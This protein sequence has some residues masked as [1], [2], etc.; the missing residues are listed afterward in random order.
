MTQS[1]KLFTIGQFADVFRK[2]DPRGFALSEVRVLEELAK[3]PE[4]HEART[5]RYK[6][7]TANRELGRA[8]ARIYD[9][10][11]QLA[12]VRDMI[13]GHQ[14]SSYR[15]LLQQNRE[16]REIANGLRTQLN[17]AAIG[18]VPRQALEEAKQPEGQPYVESGRS[19]GGLT[20]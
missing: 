6:L 20:L 17:D 13:S 8:G 15:T 19:S 10:R 12:E 14:R 4:G 3:Q 16:L 11:G 5:L 18:W 7:K 1:P 9:L 2:I